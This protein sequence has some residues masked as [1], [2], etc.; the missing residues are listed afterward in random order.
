MAQEVGKNMHG[1]EV[2]SAFPHKPVCW[3][4]FLCCPRRVLAILPAQNRPNLF[5]GD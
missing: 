4:D 2:N 1:S 3:L 5:S